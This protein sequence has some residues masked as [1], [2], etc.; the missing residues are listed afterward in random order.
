MSREGGF[1][2]AVSS[3]QKAIRRGHE[4]RALYWAHEIWSR[5]PAY[6]WRRMLIMAS[7]DLSADPM[8]AVVLG[9]L[10]MNAKLST[11][12][13]ARPV[14]GIVEAHATLFAARA[15]KSREAADAIGTVTRAKK[16]GW[17]VEPADYAVDVHTQAGR[18]LKRS[19]RHFGEHGRRV[20]GEV[21]N[22]W[23]M[24]RWGFRAEQPEDGDVDVPPVVGALDERKKKAEDE[25]SSIPGAV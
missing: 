24:R 19:Y 2:V 1:D 5:A 8:T 14:S 21:P 18:K 11:Q 22:A 15:P 3:L 25:F 9:Q 7:E 10:A 13:F 6:F 16:K 20:A 4:A 12:E 23:E 17:K